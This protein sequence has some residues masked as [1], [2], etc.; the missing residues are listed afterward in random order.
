LLND[1]ENLVRVSNN[2]DP[3]E[4]LSYSSISWIRVS[5]LK[6]LFGSTGA[7]T[8]SFYPMEKD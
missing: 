5:C 1:C 2:F 7:L 3:G 6:L 8:T 4:T